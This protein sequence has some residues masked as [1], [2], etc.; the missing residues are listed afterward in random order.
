[1]NNNILIA[2]T[3][4]AGVLSASA[5]Q[6]QEPLLAAATYFGGP[7]IERAS[8]LELAADG[9]VYIVG[10]ASAPAFSPMPGALNTLSG[11]MDI[12]VVKMTADLSDVIW[13]RY[14]GGVGQFHHIESAADAAVTPDGGLVVIGR[15][16]T[17]DFPAVHAIDSTLGG[18][19]DHVLFKLDADGDI[20]FSTYIGGSGHDG[21]DSDDDNYGE[22][23]IAPDGSIFIA[24]FTRS[25]DF[26]LVNPIDSTFGGF[27]ADVFMMKLSADGQTVLA[28]TYLGDEFR[29]QVFGMK[30][31]AHGRPVIT[32]DAG[33]GW[34]YTP[35]AYSFGTP[36]SSGLVYVTTLADDLA[37]IAWSARINISGAMLKAFDLAIAPSGVITIVGHTHGGIPVPPDAHQSQFASGSEPLDAAALQFSSDGASLVGGTY[38]GLVHATETSVSVG[39]DSFGNVIMGTHI[40]DN[41]ALVRLHKF[42]PDMTELIE[43]VVVVG[44]SSGAPLRVDEN[45]NVYQ[46]V[47]TFWADTTPGAFQEDAPEYPDE[48]PDLYIAHYDMQDPPVIVPGKPGDFNG[49][50]IVGVPDLM[51]CLASWGACADAGNCAAD[52]DGDGSVGVPDLMI[53]L[54]NWS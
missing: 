21:G 20:V 23:E 37:S 7:G 50:G 29:D 12:I 32:G 14:I 34:P 43:S 6:A 27:Q 49:D 10:S 52:L 9:S 33:P 40:Q 25:A 51:Q 19:N 11:G 41:Q 39:H 46:L 8:Q 42:N 3:I 45:N 17:P 4:V 44:S 16:E 24:G 30:I 26:P 54:Q 35:G 53:L 1:M 31:D 48:F 38:Y 18:A 47:H 22:V 13:S 5:A 15:T 2:T 28:S 36:S